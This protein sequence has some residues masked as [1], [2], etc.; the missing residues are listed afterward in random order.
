MPVRKMPYTNKARI[1]NYLMITID[2]SFAT[3]IS[4]WIDAIEV[5][6]NNYCGRE[7]ET[8]SATYKLYDGNGTREL[9]I[10]DL[11]TLTKIETLDEDGDVDDTIDSTNEYYLYP[12]NRT[13]KYK[14]RINS[15]NAPIAVFP[16]GHQN[17]KVTGTF[18]HSVTVPEA[19]RLVTT[20]L[21]AAIIR[22]SQTD[23]TGE[24]GSQ[25][26]GE[27]SVNL[28]DVDKIADRLGVKDILDQ[29]RVIPI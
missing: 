3:Q 18:G 15:F 9:L 2:A 5:W 20:K 21:V 7:F 29:Y 4:E 25:R 27:Y 19:I 26:L 17:I 11:L 23:V 14:I 6:I 1:Q 16:R 13:P 12:A 8:E 22:E 24:L 10:D 28:Q